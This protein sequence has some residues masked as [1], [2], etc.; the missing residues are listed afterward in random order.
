MDVIRLDDAGAFLDLAGSF[1]RRDEGRNQLVLG[2]AANARARRRGF[3]PFH[4]WVVLDP[5]P[6]ASAVRTPPKNLVITDGLT[7][8]AIAALVNA[9][10]ADARNT[11]G[12]TGNVPAVDRFVDEWTSR[13]GECATITI[14]QGVWVLN[15]VE[16]VPRPPGHAEPATLDDADLVTSWFI[17]FE[18]EAMPHETPQRD[19][20]RA[21]IDERLSGDDAGAWVWRVDGEPVSLVG[22]AGPTGTGIRIGPVYTP[23]E[24]RRRGYATALVADLSAH[25]LATGYELCLLYTDLA[26]P[27]A[28][29]IYASIGYRQIAES[30][31]LAFERGTSSATSTS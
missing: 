5:E 28:G 8:E 10:V 29:R 30:K 25:L 27:T 19:D 17:D 13:T 31:M 21:A 2:I 22:F 3:V 7:D 14:A 6:V 24:Q 11:P 20:V 9:L 4:A 12:V 16:D 23:P 26:N 1:A 18:I 15:A